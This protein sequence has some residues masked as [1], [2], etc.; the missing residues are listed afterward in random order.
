M[1]IPTVSVVLPVFNGE[2]FVLD[3][4]KSIQ[5]Q[6]FSDWEII[7][8]DDGSTDGSL[9]LCRKYSLSDQ[10]IRV[11][12][13]KVNL[14]LAKTMNKLVSLAEGRYIAIQEQDDISLPH[15][16]ELEVDLL[17]NNPEVALVSGVAA[18]LDDNGMISGHFPA[19]LYD[20]EAYPETKADMVTYLYTEQC[21][22]VNTACMFRR[23]LIDQ[24]AGP[25]DEGAKC[26]IDW[27]FFLHAA[28]LVKI[29]GLPQTLVQM[30]RGT[31]HN[32]ITH[33][34]N[35]E[36]KL[37]EGRRCIKLIFQKYKD[38]THSPINSILYKKA[39]ATQ[40]ILEGRSYGKVR[41][42]LRLIQA[43][44]YDPFNYNVWSSIGDAFLNLWNKIINYR[45]TFSDKSES[46][47]I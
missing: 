41:G 19:K 30:R 32:H 23:T 31:Q 47:R 43:I 18:W 7:I 5:E 44:F 27:Q 21:K 20:G 17:S 3:A 46:Q 16:L 29:A 45:M 37:K 15:R 8:I 22:I 25:F 35:K 33:P 1:K 11:Y 38:K 14:G 36:E 4:I 42:L 12:A 24:I 39:M 40:L 10:R 28:H 2:R 9:E 26:A 34:K 6:T 13:N